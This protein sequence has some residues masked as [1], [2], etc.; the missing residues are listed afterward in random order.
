MTSAGDKTL[1]ETQTL[2]IRSFSP[3]GRDRHRI[4]SMENGLMKAE[5]EVSEYPEH[6]VEKCPLRWD[7]LER[8]FSP[9]HYPECLDTGSGILKLHSE[10]QILLT[11]CFCKALNL[12]YYVIIGK[13]I[14]RRRINH[15]AWKLYEIQISVS[16]STALLEQSHTAYLHIVYCCFYI[17]TTEL[18]GQDRDCHAHW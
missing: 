12:F 16:K 18:S 14:N 2:P 10:G 13:K 15:N 5:G 7:L 1:C 4:T 8:F 6:T 17:V 9:G 3:S 11:S